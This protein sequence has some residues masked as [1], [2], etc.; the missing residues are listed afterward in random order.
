MVANFFGRKHCYSIVCDE[1]KIFMLYDNGGRTMTTIVI[2]PSFF[3]L[4]D[5]WCRSLSL[6]HFI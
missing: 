2:S 6:K 5:C 1:S 4:F 3:V